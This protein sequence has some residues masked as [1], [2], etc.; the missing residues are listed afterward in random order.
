MNDV[1]NKRNDHIHISQTHVVL[2]RNYPACLAPEAHF[3][4]RTPSTK[5]SE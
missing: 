3:A 2:V 5:L 1:I 4:S